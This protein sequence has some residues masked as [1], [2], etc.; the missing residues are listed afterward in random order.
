MVLEELDRARFQGRIW[1]CAQFLVDAQFPDGLWSYG[2]RTV[3]PD[4][5]LAPNPKAVAPAGV[6]STGKKKKPPVT[7]K[8][9]VKKTRDGIGVREHVN[10]SSGMY[11]ALGLRACHDAGIVLPREVLERGVKW[12]RKH[13]MVEKQD[14]GTAEAA[15]ATGDRISWRYSL[16]LPGDPPMPNIATLSMTTGAVGSLVVYDYLLGSDWKKDKVVNGGMNWIADRFSVV[17][18][19]GAEGVWKHKRTFHFYYLYALER[20]GVLYDT[21]TVGSHNWYSEGAALLLGEQKPDGSWNN[22]G[23]WLG[24]TGDSQPVWDTCFA[25]LFLKRATPPLRDVASEDRFIRGQEDPPQK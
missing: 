2:E 19:V 7:R 6:D 13:Q 21:P 22:A 10:N 23:T 20:L 14:K 5:P 24:N 15:G 4:P 16:S 1:Q 17:E 9:V 11:A 18:N 3:V 8:L 25:I 12:W